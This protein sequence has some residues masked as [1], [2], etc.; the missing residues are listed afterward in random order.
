MPQHLWRGDQRTFRVCEV[1]L[2]PQVHERGEWYPPLHPICPGDDE[3]D[4]A[5]R[6]PP[7][8]PP[9]VLELA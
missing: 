1:C 2:A 4:G 3:D 9:R 8:G 5:R 6:A 7:S